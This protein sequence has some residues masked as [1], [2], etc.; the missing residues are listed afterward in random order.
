MNATIRSVI[1]ALLVAVTA[2]AAVPQSQPPRTSVG[3][4]LDISIVNVDVVVT[5]RSG[6]RVR[7]LTR[8]DFELLENGNTRP[9]TNFAEYRSRTGDSRTGVVADAFGAPMGEG[10]APPP[11]SIVLF[12]DSFALPGHDADRMFNALKKTIHDAVRA[13]DV[14]SIVRWNPIWFRPEVVV[15]YTSDNRKLT[16]AVEDLRDEMT[17]GGPRRNYT[18]VRGTGMVS[19]DTASLIGGPRNPQARNTAMREEGI[20]VSNTMQSRVSGPRHVVAATDDAVLYDA[21]AQATLALWEQRRKVG[22][23][24]ALI[25]SMATMEGRKALILATHRMGYYAG[26]EYFYAYG[27]N[28]VP[29]HDRAAFDTRPL[30]D[31]MI[32][33]A[34]AAGVTIYPVYPEG[35][36][37]DGALP[38]ASASSSQ[39]NAAYD[40]LVL[41]NETSALAN[42]ALKTGGM[43]AWGASD[44][45]TLLPRINDDLDSYYSLAYRTE[46]ATKDTQRAISVKTKNPDYIVRA[47]REYAATTEETKM[48]QRVTAAVFRE[49]ETASRINVK[50]TFG[51]PEKEGKDKWR[52]PLSLRIPMSQLVALPSASGEKAGS[53]SIYV[54]SSATLG[55]NAEVTRQTQPFTYPEAN[56]ETVS[57]QYVTYDVD[58]LV[59]KGAEFIAVGV[60]DDV[61][62]DASVMRLRLPRR[63]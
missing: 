48:R 30:M 53:M 58:V 40:H 56:A 5:D 38:N 32:D 46:P 8:D 52:V 3:E 12:V 62:R 19:P 4:T 23:I 2:V 47:R 17:L 26:A 13:G 1:A 37:T 10:S 43:M 9:I 15:P 45:A 25:S 60:V 34:N 24:N 44:V 33:T 59:D 11:R 6:N 39:L 36:G 55:T 28:D 63:F 51:R 54:A 57:K 50:A 22:V 31:S 42:V 27:F 49:P 35:L 41:T 29:P 18:N 7:G 21:R 14:A 16:R 20:R 61:S